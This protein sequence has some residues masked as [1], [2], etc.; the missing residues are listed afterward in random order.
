[1]TRRIRNTYLQS[2]CKVYKFRMEDEIMT[3]RLTDYEFMKE[4]VRLRIISF[5]VSFDFDSLDV[6]LFGTVR[7]RQIPFFWKIL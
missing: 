3:K 2:C 5:L 4:S 7:V 1:M 6:L